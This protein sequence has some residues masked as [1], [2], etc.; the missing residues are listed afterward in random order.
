MRL[1]HSALHTAGAVAEPRAPLIRSGLAKTS[2]G[3]LYFFAYAARIGRRSARHALIQAKKQRPSRAH[4]VGSAMMPSPPG[5]ARSPRPTTLE[6]DTERTI[7][8]RNSSLDEDTTDVL[9]H[10]E[11]SPSPKG[12]SRAFRSESPRRNRLSSDDIAPPDDD[13]EAIIEGAEEGRLPRLLPEGDRAA[14]IERL[15]TDLFE[16]QRDSELSASQRR[17]AS[18]LPPTPVSIYG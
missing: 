15:R 16:V 8:R 3:H 5:R 14:L 4:G 6:V 7:Q 1:Q 11:A 10:L 17:P 18:P 2:R 9:A 12:K 13:V